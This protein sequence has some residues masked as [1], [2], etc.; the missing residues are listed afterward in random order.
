MMFKE[1]P[2]INIRDISYSIDGKYLLN[3]TR[4]K[5]SGNGITVVLG[6]NGAGKT[7]F[8]KLLSGLLKAGNGEIKTGSKDFSFRN[9]A[10][11][12]QEPIIL[13][14]SV[15]SNILFVLNKVQ[16]HQKIMAS[17]LIDTLGL[18]GKNNQSALTLSAGEKQRLSLAR[19]LITQPRILLLDEPT[20]NIEPTSTIYIEKV[21]AK[22]SSSGTKIFFV[23]HDI[24]QAKRLANDIIYV[25]NGKVLEYTNSSV[26]FKKPITVNAQKYIS[27]IISDAQTNN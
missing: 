24:N 13:R 15:M 8:L 21:L 5:I 10:M 14:R 27:G 18:S 16:P 12:S 3:K 25:E 6:A 22:K 26:F 1:N 4:L 2:S 9:S 23:T 17:E 20:A 11:V 7:I 19:A